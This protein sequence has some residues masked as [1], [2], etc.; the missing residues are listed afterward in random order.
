M[1]NLLIAVFVLLVLLASGSLFAVKEGERAIVIQFGKVQRDEA[2]G[3]T[4]VFEPGLHFKLPFIDSVRHLDARI[5]TLDG[6]PDRF[7]T[8]EKKDLIVDSYVKWRIEDFARYY[9]STGGNKLQAE[10]L[11][12]QKVNNG[13]RS[14][15]GTRT[16]AQ[17]VS[18]ERSAL[19]NQAMEQAS[20]SSDELGIEIVDV[21]VKQINLPTEV[22]NSIFQRMRAE[23]AAVARE[24]RSEGQEQAEVIKAN[25]DAKVTVMLA[26]AERNARQLRG[27]GDAIAAQIYADAYS[28]NADFYSFLRS[29]DAYKQ[30][31]NSKQDVMVI[32]P[33]SDFFKYMNN[34]K[35]N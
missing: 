3:E 15:F 30:S 10:A 8:S 12:K 13:L 16:I 9:L 2:T 17:I 24:H 31:F 29:M 33:D 7:V 4:R 21:R 19:M 32:A 25:I 1:K 34:S 27:E 26:D 5:Q 23:R 6:T 18:G 22:S 14:E 35:G 20:T 28:K 11:L